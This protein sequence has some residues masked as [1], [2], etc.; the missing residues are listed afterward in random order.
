MP[1]RSLEENL[2]LLLVALR[3]AGET[4]ITIDQV[5]T[6]TFKDTNL[7][8]TDIKKLFEHLRTKGYIHS[9]VGK[10]DVIYTIV[11]GR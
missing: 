8:K 2:S 11:P 5:K 10:L 4:G 3:D 9:K 6:Q 7:S 1:N